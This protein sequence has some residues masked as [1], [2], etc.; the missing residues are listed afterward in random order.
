MVK[1]KWLLLLLFIT[2]F[3]VVLIALLAYQKLQNSSI[4]KRYYVKVTVIYPLN[5]T[6]ITNAVV[7]ILSTNGRIIAQQATDT[8]GQAY[9]QLSSGEYVIQIASGYIGEV[10]IDLHSDQ[11]VKLEVLPVLR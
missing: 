11:S 4:D 3:A 7:E 6:P 10:E 9:F 5:D 2:G 1:R 8:K